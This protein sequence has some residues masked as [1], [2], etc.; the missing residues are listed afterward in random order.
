M[1]CRLFRDPCR[2]TSW[3]L[4]QTR[5]FQTPSRYYGVAVTSLHEALNDTRYITRTQKQ[6][7]SMQTRPASRRDK[8]GPCKINRDAEKRIRFRGKLSSGDQY[9]HMLL[10]SWAQYRHFLPF[11]SRVYRNL[12]PILCYAF[13]IIS[14]LKV[15]AATPGIW[16]VKGWVFANWFRQRWFVAVWWPVRKEKENGGAM[17]FSVIFNSWLLQTH[18]NSRLCF[19]RRSQYSV[20]VHY[21]TR[22]IGKRT[23]G[24]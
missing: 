1:I 5:W 2:R 10:D 15:H 12:L 9:Y 21:N 4:E 14:I 7:G 22:D 16:H 11:T 17:L 13:I 20:T 23:E 3:C 6:A 8:P 24:T 19:S 18:R